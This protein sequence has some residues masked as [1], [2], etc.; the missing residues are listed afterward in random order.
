MLFY[1]VCSVNLSV[2]GRDAQSWCHV[3]VNVRDE[4]KL[5]CTVLSSLTVTLIVTFDPSI[6]LLYT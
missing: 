3:K 2:A 4:S 6:V 5:G 1:V